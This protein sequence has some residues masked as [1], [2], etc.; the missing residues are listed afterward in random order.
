MTEPNN[1]SAFNA[2]VGT[3]SFITFSVFMFCVATL[4]TCVDIKKLRELDD[5]ALKNYMRGGIPEKNL[6]TPAGIVRYNTAAVTL[7][8]S[9]ILFAVLY[10]FG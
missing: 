3:L 9:M 7:I 6:L 2:L 10:C 1:I 5:E 4:R 8:I